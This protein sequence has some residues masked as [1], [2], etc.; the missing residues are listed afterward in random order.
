[1]NFE[2]ILTILL[3]RN[4]LKSLRNNKMAMKDGG[5]NHELDFG[6]II[7]GDKL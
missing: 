6:G 1:M 5:K 3:L 4:I 2:V 7:F